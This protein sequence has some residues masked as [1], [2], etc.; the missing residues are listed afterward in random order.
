MDAEA[1]ISLT[2]LGGDRGALTVLWA[3]LSRIVVVSY[4]LFFFVAS[5]GLL[6]S[7]LV[8]NNQ[9]ALS[10][11]PCAA[12][13]IT[14]PVYGLL[15]WRLYT[16]A[17]PVAISIW[18]ERYL[19]AFSLH[20]TFLSDYAPILE[21]GFKASWMIVFPMATLLLYLTLFLTFLLVITPLG[22][23]LDSKY[24]YALNIMSYAA[25]VIQIAVLVFLIRRGKQ[26]VVFFV[27]EQYVSDGTPCTVVPLKDA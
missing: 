26:A 3:R 22:D 27:G 14:I 1:D 24:R 12:A 16:I 9:Y 15:M 20:E 10:M 11:V 8:K 25:V 21:F 19:S 7:Q 6:A 23:F 4:A 17:I 13:V 18:T 5:D 2:Q